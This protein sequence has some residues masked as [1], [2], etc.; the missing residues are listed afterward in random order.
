MGSAAKNRVGGIASLV[1]RKM[2][3][4]ARNVNAKK[5]N[6]VRGSF[7]AD[8]KNIVHLIEL[9]HTSSNYRSSDQMT[10]N[11]N[12]ASLS[13]AAGKVSPK[14]CGPVCKK[15]CEY[16]FQKNESG[17]EI[18]KCNEK[19]GMWPCSVWRGDEYSVL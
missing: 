18:C 8:N 2:K 5:R 6:Q 9:S 11:S 3:T 7:H 14:K 15:F 12:N 16:G 13:I 1:L 10:W 19:P 4:V 17:C